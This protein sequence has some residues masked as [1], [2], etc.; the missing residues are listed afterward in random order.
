[1]RGKEDVANVATPE[2]QD[3]GRF[4]L[5]KLSVKKNSGR[6]ADGVKIRTEMG[7]GGSEHRRNNSRL[8]QGGRWKGGSRITPRLRVYVRSAL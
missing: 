1:M 5:G 7:I 8:Q 4:P 3:V 2:K 6:V